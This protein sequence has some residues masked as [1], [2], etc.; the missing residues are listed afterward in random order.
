MVRAAHERSTTFYVLGVVWL[1]AATWLIAHDLA[2]LAVVGSI[3][4]GIWHF[5]LRDKFASEETD[6]AYS[7]FNKGGRSILGGFTGE[8]LEGQLR[9][10]GSNSS[11]SSAKMDETRPLVTLSSSTTTTTTTPKMKEKNKLRQRSAAA[12]AAERR[13]QQKQQQ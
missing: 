6:S 9:G 4:L 2:V 7:V 13:M 11:S 12:A 10:T 1:V 5:G 8:Q 3:G